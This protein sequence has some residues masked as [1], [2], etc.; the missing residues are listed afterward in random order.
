MIL[1]GTNRSYDQMEYDETVSEEQI[2]DFCN[3]LYQHAL[4]LCNT[5][6]AKIQLQKGV[7]TS[8]FLGN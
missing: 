8:C 2:T 3:R 7:E 6:E 4:E 1:E 5:D